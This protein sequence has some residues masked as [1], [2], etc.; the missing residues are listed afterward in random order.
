MGQIH[1]QGLVTECDIPSS[2][3]RGWPRHMIYTS[4]FSVHLAGPSSQPSL[5]ST[6]IT[7]ILICTSDA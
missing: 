1:F 2:G 4:R 3:W 6:T 5:Q 7:T